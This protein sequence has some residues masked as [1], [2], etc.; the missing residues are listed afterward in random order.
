MKYTPG[1]FDIVNKLKK[2][3]RPNAGQPRLVIFIRIAP[4]LS[5]GYPMLMTPTGQ[6]SEASTAASCDASG[7][8]SRIT[9]A[10]PSSSI[11]NTS[12][13]VPA[14]SPHPMH[15]L[16][17]ISAFMLISFHKRLVYSNTP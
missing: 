13:Q 4:V 5:Y 15:P 12:G 7:I 1:T 2:R 3:S 11:S 17:S 10:K 9:L 16:L 14:Q 8:S 6:P